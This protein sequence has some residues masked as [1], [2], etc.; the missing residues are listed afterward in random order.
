MKKYKI[1]CTASYISRNENGENSYSYVI[2][3]N[4]QVEA[5]G[6]AKLRVLEDFSIDL[7]I[8]NS[9]QL[10]SIKVN[11]CIEQTGD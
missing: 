11:N 1:N 6:I 4:N 7:N 10:M 9:F 2:T 8:D 5:E 3:S